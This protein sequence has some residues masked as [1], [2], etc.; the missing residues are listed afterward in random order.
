MRFVPS[1]IRKALCGAAF[2][3]VLAAAGSIATPRPLEASPLDGL[4]N[5]GVESLALQWFE[6]MRTGDIDRGGLSRDYSLQLSDAAVQA[7][8]NYLQQYAYGA[9]PLGAEVVKTRTLP[10]QTLYVVKLIFP[11]GNSANLL[12]GVNAEGRIAGLSVMSMA[13]D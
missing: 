7:M 9:T 10:D 6:R 12:I 8:S 4:T 13:G 5:Q 11:R 1:I 2:C 3:A